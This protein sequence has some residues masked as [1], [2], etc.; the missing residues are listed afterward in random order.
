MPLAA[1]KKESS[2]EPARKA[3]ERLR[4]AAGDAATDIRAVS[5]ILA[6]ISSIAARR[7]PM[8]LVRRRRSFEWVRDQGKPREF[9]ARFLA[10][11]TGYQRR[12]VAYL[13]SRVARSMVEHLDA[14]FEHPERCVLHEDLVPAEIF[15]A[16]GLVPWMCEMLGIM[17]PLLN[18]DMGE[19][20]ID[21]AENAGTPPDVCSLPKVSMGLVLSGQMP[22]PVAVVSSNMPCDGGM[23]SYGVI[24]KAIG[25]PAFYL[26]VP[27]HFYSERA[28]DYFVEELKRLIA[29]LEETT[30][31]RM[32]WDRLREV[33]EERNR[34]VEY[35]I[36]LWDLAA[37]K[38]AP[39]AAEP[40]Y[41]SHLI[42]M[43]TYPGTPESTEVFRTMVD[44][45]QKAVAKGEPALAEERYR[46]ALW[47]PPTLSC[48]D[49]WVWAEKRWGVAGIMD[50]LTY[51][52]QPFIDTKS[53]ESMLRG[54]ARIIM[55]GPMARHTR[56]PQENFF[57]DLFHLYERFSLDMIW[58]A[59]HVG[60]KNTMALNGIFREKCR[61][62]DIPL[63]NIRYDLADRRIVS[64]PDVKAQVD[65][66]METVMKASPLS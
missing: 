28:E 27:F 7:G 1:A 50:M 45:A 21:A 15:T 35:E 37:R 16:M 13:L 11:R 2:L 49:L 12:A 64:P 53:P 51:N 59:G 60:C 4:R 56:G 43:C 62:R 31:G 39:L 8:A 47:N 17:V 19:R 3:L 48:A 58:M 32:D 29:W 20:A 33:C 30:P 65:S 9:L 52:R 23:T 14:Y 6:G 22:K 41:F 66:F 54:L 57:N 36:A 61:E 44:F 18:P 10:H 26:D 55:Q 63:L 46:A 5:S 42:F 24:R 40:V 34:A 25:V 38:P